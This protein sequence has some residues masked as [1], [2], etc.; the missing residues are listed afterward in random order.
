MSEQE[1]RAR[2]IAEASREK[3]WRGG[4][5]LKELLL[6][7]L[8]LDLLEPYPDRPERPEFQAFYGRLERFLRERVDPVEIDHTGEIPLDV[9]RGLA[10]LGAFGM[11]I[12]T[13]YAGLGLSHAEYVQVMKLVGSYDANLT[14]LL[15]AH[16]AIGVPQP[17]LLFG[18]EE[19]KQRYL[20]RCAQGAISAFALTEPAVGSDPGRLASIARPSPEG[21][22]YILSGRKLWCTNGTLADVIVVMARN[23]DTDRINAFVVEMGWEGVR[24]E[25]RC[26][27]MGL[28][29]LANAQLAFD[30]VEVPRHNRIGEE[31]DGLRIALAT[32]N[33]GRLTLPAATAGGAKAALE[34]S[35]KWANARVQW[36][37]PIG[38]H[39]AVAHMVS[40]IAATAFAMEALADT[41]GALADRDGIDIRLEAAAAKEWN[42]TRGWQLLDDALQVRGGRGYETERSLAAR[43]EP[44]VPM[45]RFLRDQ[46]INRI[47]EGSSEILHLFM[48]RE[49]L[50]RHLQVAGALVDPEARLK[51]RLKALPRIALFY[52]WWFPT[53]IVRLPRPG[54]YRSF[55][56]LARHVR[57]A[58]RAGRRLARSL[59]YGMLVHRA[60]LERR[61]GF[62][63][64]A[65]AIGVE[66]FALVLA[67]MRAR[68]LGRAGS[69]EA[70]AARDLVEVFARQTRR[71]VRRLFRQL[72]RNDDRRRSA[73]ARGVLAGDYAWLEEGAMGLGLSEDELRPPP[74]TGHTEPSAAPAGAA[75]PQP[76]ADSRPTADSR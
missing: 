49:A 21:G 10:E 2:Q 8:R 40:G 28:R 70:A 61:Q 62:L 12:P 9:I 58:E 43:G 6:G 42:T 7:E 22:R 52:A 59:F 60:G 34:I 32:L 24:V 63:F 46:R 31:G 66:L 4:S 69:S 50:D 16:Q 56:R 47:F 72:W 18:S 73:L 54:R 76:V 65:V 44:P 55:G 29:A 13:L 5:F 45:E 64:R 20:P 37:A 71:R 75:A 3:R 39:E 26:R 51:D 57:F 17:V 41:V 15:S 38:E 25:H 27:F 68:A 67:A 11:K 53:R 19:L 30:E 48:A 23:P 74:V 1:Q 14:A 36:G 33:T 35:R